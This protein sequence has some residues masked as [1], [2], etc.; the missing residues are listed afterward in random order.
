MRAVLLGGLY[1]LF[2]VLVK[3]LKYG[4]SAITKGIPEQTNHL[5]S[6]YQPDCFLLLQFYCYRKELDIFRFLLDPKIHAHYQFPK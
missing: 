1:P 2:K 5:T 6:V 3:S 4:E